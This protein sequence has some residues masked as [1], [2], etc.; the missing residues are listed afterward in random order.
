MSFAVL[1]ALWLLQA[2]EGGVTSPDR[3]ERAV[4]VWQTRHMADSATNQAANR[5][6]AYEEQQFA[7]KFNDLVERLRE[8][9][10]QY[11]HHVVDL[12][13]IKALKKA[14]RDFEKTDAWFR[15][16]ERTGH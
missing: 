9:A 15:L 11:N 8:F 6:A 5:E 4:A 14:W 3:M 13:K 1:C 2:Q 10:E 7:N 12:K 16:D